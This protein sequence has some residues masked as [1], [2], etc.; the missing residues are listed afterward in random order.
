MGCLIFT[1]INLIFF[2]VCGS[3]CLVS[4]PTPVC[5][6]EAA[7][8]LPLWGG[9]S[10]A[11]S[12]LR[13][14]YEVSPTP[15]FLLITLPASSWAASN[16]LYHLH[17]QR[18]LLASLCRCLYFP[19]DLKKTIKRPWVAAAHGSRSPQ[20]AFLCGAHASLKARAARSFPLWQTGCPHWTPES[21]CASVLFSRYWLSAPDV[22]GV[23]VSSTLWQQA[24]GL[25]PWH[26][27]RG[28]I[29]TVGNETEWGPSE[30]GNWLCKTPWSS[31]AES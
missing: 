23:G 8:C 15:S 16:A 21:I 19:S 27:C 11:M 10:R 24:C 12:C 7:W 3:G 26:R 29:R 1:F 2:P 18:E 6:G 28:E 20:P 17:L 31:N 30:R 9:G 4:N 22:P 13:R 25:I 14:V 5:L